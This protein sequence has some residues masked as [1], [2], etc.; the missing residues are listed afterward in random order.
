MLIAEYLQDADKKGLSKIS[1]DVK[2]LAQKARENSLKPDD[3]EVESK[4]N[5]LIWLWL[6]GCCLISLRY[7]WC[8]VELLLCQILE[9]LLESNNSVLSLIL[10]RQPFL[11]LALVN[12]LLLYKALFGWTENIQRENTTIN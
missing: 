9:G 2:N 1:E 6:C 3:Y 7:F 8:R 12:N 10:L 11:Q 4:Y 5:I